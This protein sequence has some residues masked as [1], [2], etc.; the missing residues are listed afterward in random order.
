MSDPA[1]AGAQAAKPSAV[2]VRYWFVIALLIV[3]ADQASKFAIESWLDR[4]QS[5]ALTGFLNLALAYNPGAAFSLLAGAGGWQRW[6][7][8]AIA[9][10]A[11][12]ALPWLIQ[13]H[14]RERLFCGALALIL[15]GAMGN[16]WDRV[17]HGHVVD[18]I[19]FHVAG[20]HWPAFNIAD[21]AISVGAVLL[22]I[23]GFRP[24]RGA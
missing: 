8:I 3:I 12:V 20:W 21:S 7:F 4:G 24:R 22:I 2:A 9:V 19:D 14:R 15:G 6:F 10:F 13:R 5:V 23:D 11:C 16:L 18:F 1:A 17:V